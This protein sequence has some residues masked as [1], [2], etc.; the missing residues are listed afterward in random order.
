[1]QKISGT[2]ANV[3]LLI[4][5]PPEKCWKL[6]PLFLHFNTVFNPAAKIA[7]YIIHQL[8][9]IY[10]L[11]RLAS[12]QIHTFYAVLSLQFLFL[13]LFAVAQADLENSFF[14]PPLL[15]LDLSFSVYGS[16]TSSDEWCIV[17]YLPGKGVI[18]MLITS[19]ILINTGKVASIQ[20]NWNWHGSRPGTVCL[21]VGRSPTLIHAE[22]S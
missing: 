17:F 8:L 1:M 9:V 7:S 13:C 19:K 14:F 12:L 2:P 16:R 6:K 3:C 10:S 22:M 4:C 20:S 21:A 18:T 11:Q 5:I 15:D